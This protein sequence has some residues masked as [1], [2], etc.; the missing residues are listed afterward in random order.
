VSDE[1]TSNSRALISN[2]PTLVPIGF[3]VAAK[4]SSGVSAWCPTVEFTLTK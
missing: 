4:D 1:A 2:L 3:E